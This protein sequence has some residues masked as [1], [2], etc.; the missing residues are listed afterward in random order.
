MWSIKPRPGL[1][2][3]CCS[4]IVFFRGSKSVRNNRS[5]QFS[6]NESQANTSVVVTEG[7]LAFL[8]IEITVDSPQ[9]RGTDYD[10]QICSNK[11]V[12][13]LMKLDFPFFNRAG[14]K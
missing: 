2:P 13:K 5:E 1:K 14:G 4:R 6:Y 8:K 9:F 11:L 10:R 3:A 12:N 7:F